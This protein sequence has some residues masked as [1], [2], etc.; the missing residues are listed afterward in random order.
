VTLQLLEPSASPWN[1]KWP[2]RLEDG[3]EVE[4]VLYRGDTLCISSQVGCAVRCPFCASG[5]NGLGRSLSYDELVAQVDAVESAGHQVARVTV[6]GV[7]E[8]L[9]N[10]ESVVRFLEYARARNTPASVTTTGGPLPRLLELLAAPHNGVTVS[11]HAGTE[12][13]RA[14]MVPHGPPL[15]PLVETLAAAL[16]AMAR[17][18]RKKVALA[19]LIVEGDND[20]DAELHAFADRVRVLGAPVHLYA[21]NPVV[22]SQARPTSRARYEAAYALLRAA[23]L[24]VR[25]SSQAR[26]DPNGGCGTLVALRLAKTGRGALAG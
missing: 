18:R 24:V 5:A 15:G 23:G 8:P 26:I 22:T 7:G 17:K 21:L 6:S 16:P 1:V 2:V 4:A 3:N 12:S 13:V 19:Y 9:H 25:M 20:D 11:V 14:R 10:A